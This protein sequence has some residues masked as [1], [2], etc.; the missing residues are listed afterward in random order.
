MQPTTARF[1]T[2]FGPV[3]VHG[4][5]TSERKP[6]SL[7][8]N[9]KTI[10]VPELHSNTEQ[11]RILETIEETFQTKFAQMDEFIKGQQ[12]L[13]RDFQGMQKTVQE[14]KQLPQILETLESRIKTEQNARITE[15]Q[16][17][18]KTAFDTNQQTQTGQFQRIEQLLSGLYSQSS[19]DKATTEQA[20]ERLQSNVDNLNGR[21]SE[22]S[23]PSS[24]EHKKVKTVS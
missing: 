8:S 6:Q 16:N 3:I 12:T 5:E 14:L 4:I 13:Q 22:G 2:S 19:K 7:G 10:E 17:L 21:S 9:I 1:S 23:S 11:K 18:F 15:F 24:P 20:L